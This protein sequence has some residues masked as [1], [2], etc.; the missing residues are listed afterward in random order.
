MTVIKSNWNPAAASKVAVTQFRDR[1]WEQTPNYSSTPKDQLPVNPYSDY[2]GNLNQDFWN[3][4]SYYLNG[5][6]PFITTPPQWEWDG[7]TK[8]NIG[9]GF[10]DKALSTGLSA[11]INECTVKLLVK[12]ADQKA[13]IAVML[14]EASKTSDLILGKARQIDRAYRA[15]RRGRLKEVARILNIGPTRVH[16]TWLEYKYGWMPLMYD[17]KNAAEFFAQQAMGRRPSYYVKQSVKNSFVYDEVVMQTEYGMT[18]PLVPS[19]RHCKVD[20][21][22]KQKI[23][24]ELTSPN[25]AALQQTGVT[26]PELYA[27]EVMPYSFVIDWF[28]S[29]GDWLTSMTALN[30]IA[31]RRAVQSIEKSWYATY[32]VPESKYVSGPYVYISG[33]RHCDVTSREYNRSVLSINP[34]DLYPPAN[35]DAFGFQK[36]VTSLA[37]L[38]SA[39]PP[40]GA[41]I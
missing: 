7:T 31:I 5:S 10:R 39:R 3:G 13:N 41:R 22:V 24:V 28:I 40:A 4:R 33:K 19:K 30:G 36:L 16:K 15:F 1:S 29:V 37:L 38:R 34:W 21:T 8:Y 23:W 11:L 26:N 2:R 17:A 27:W 25:L 12:T 14:K 9:K 35:R 32:D 18:Q 20:V 6:G